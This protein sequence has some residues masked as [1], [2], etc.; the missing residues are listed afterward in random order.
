MTSEASKGNLAVTAASRFLAGLGVI[1]ALLFV[2]AG[3]LDYWQ[4]WLYL[5]ILFL[6]LVLVA[7][8]LVIRAPE[9]VERRMRTREQQSIQWW[10]IGVSGLSMVG[11]YLVSALDYRFSWSSVPL[12]LTLA[13]DVLILAGYAFFAWA[14]W[15]N[16]YASRVVEVQAGQTVTKAGPYRF[17]RHPMY[18]GMILMFNLS[19]IALGSWWGL[20]AG[21]P[22]P[23]ALIVRISHEE[24]MLTEGLP[25]YRTYKQQVP[26]RLIPFLW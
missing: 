20:L 8:L 13:A 11:I 5:A 22:F 18:L 2:P 10:V 4:A 3:T 1:G 9:L 6:P 21:A 17:V 16:R 24:E 12:P 7:S 25:G 15:E 19:P 26:H 14:M 23:I